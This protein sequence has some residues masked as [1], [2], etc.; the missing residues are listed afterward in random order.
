M[1]RASLA[2]WAQPLGAGALAGLALV[3]LYLGLVS[4]AQGLGH[5]REL[6]W[7]DRYFVTAI[8][9]GFGLQV[10]LF[11]HLRRLLARRAA[12]STLGVTATGT[13]TSTVAMLACCAHHVTDALALLGLSG[14]TIFLSDYRVPLMAVGLAVNALGVA[15]ML[16]LLVIAHPSRQE[17]ERGMLRLLGP[18]AM[19]AALLA[20]AC[21]SG[22]GGKAEPGAA[23]PSGPKLTQA[24]EAGGVSVEATWL[25]GDDASA[26]APDL[27]T[28]PLGEFV[29]VQIEFTTHSGDLNEIDLEESVVLSQGA[30]ELRPEAWVSTD[31]DAH[32]RA[33]FLVFPRQLKDGSVE[34]T[35]DMGDGALALRWESVPST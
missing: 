2:A 30:A 27:S 13:G 8:A 18:A 23:V 26:T 22:D 16:R 28:Y 6:L 32:H 3:A 1:P 15:F 34:L 31:D 25:T 12:G 4:W 29:L 24:A 14:A 10:G 5:A 19:A 20:A 33:G 17:G 9:T 21:S 35:I 11:V 7:D